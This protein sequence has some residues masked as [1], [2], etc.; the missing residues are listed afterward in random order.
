MGQH[1][2]LV[3]QQQRGGSADCGPFVASD[4][5]TTGEDDELVSTQDDPDPMAD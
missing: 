3:I 5:P 4:L 2:E 1:L